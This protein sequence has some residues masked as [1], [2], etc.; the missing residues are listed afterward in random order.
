MSWSNP[1]IGGGN[2]LI[3]ESIHSPD[4]VT[5]VSG[6]TINKDGSAEFNDVTV[7]GSLYVTGPQGSSVVIDATTPSDPDRWFF[8]GVSTSL[9]PTQ[10][11][12]V[13]TD[14]GLIAA[15]NTDSSGASLGTE[16][17]GVIIYS[18]SYNDSP[19]SPELESGVTMDL[20]SGQYS[21]LNLSRRPQIIIRNTAQA[22]SSNARFLDIIANGLT[23]PMGEIC[24]VSSTSA[25]SAIGT[26]ET[27][28]LDSDTV[29][30]SGVTLY[31]GRT[32]RIVVMGG[33]FSTTGSSGSFGVTKVRVGS[34][35]GTV[36][37]ESF[38]TATP[39]SGFVYNNYGEA[40]FSIPYSGTSSISRRF[41]C[42]LT[43]SS[44]TT[45]SH[46]GN[47]D[48]PRYFRITDIGYSGANP[49]TI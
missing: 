37:Y 12:H 11:P 34:V 24:Y 19:G 6:W 14:E 29:Y 2:A 38:R 33:V 8:G 5:G 25:S 4:Y 46:Y 13:Y 32:Y 47:A 17:P 35:T 1:I 21:G 10:G 39:T 26:T 18:P 23:M 30:S 22:V 42:T 9:Q 16:G 27:I 48:T 40:V 31:E 7:R 43:S 41:V 45:T 36:L 20:F 49:K 15:Y 44:G 28:V 3:R